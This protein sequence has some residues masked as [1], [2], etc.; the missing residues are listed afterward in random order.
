MNADMSSQT[1]GMTPFSGKPAGGR[2]NLV[3][4]KHNR[5]NI[6]TEKCI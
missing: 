4:E 6:M 3:W 5:D 2:Q 1:I